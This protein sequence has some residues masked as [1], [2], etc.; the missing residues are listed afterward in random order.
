MASRIYHNPVVHVPQQGRERR[1]SW[2]EL[3]YDLA[4]VAVLIQLGSSLAAHSG[5]RGI[6]GFVVLFVPVWIAWTGFTFYSNRF[7]V[8]DVVHRVSVFGQIFATSAMAL[9]VPEVFEGQTSHFALSYAVLR[10]LQLIMYLRTWWQEPS[11]QVFTRHFAFVYAVDA[12]LW[13]LSTMLLSPWN[14]LAWLLGGLAS[15][16]VPFSSQAHQL[17][18]KYSPDAAHMAERYGLL[19][20]IVLG[21]TFLKSLTSLPGHPVG[22]QIGVVSAMIVIAFGIWWIY[23]DDVAGSRL[24]TSRLTTFAWIYSHLPLTMAITMIGVSAKKFITAASMST[25]VPSARWILCLSVATVLACMA[26]LD[27]V[28]ERRNVALNDR[29]RIQIRLA[30]AGIVILLGAA[31]ALLPPLVLLSLVAI[32]VLVQ[33]IAD[34]AIAPHD[35]SLHGQVID[36]TVGTGSRAVI[37]PTRNRS[38]TPTAEALRLG[39]PSELRSDFYFYLL[40]GSW[41]RLIASLLGLYVALNFVFA[42]LYVIGPNSILNARSNSLADAFFFSVQ[43]MS[44][45][46][47]GTM[48][49]GTTYG[50]IIMTIEMMASLMLV[51]VATGLMFAKAARPKPSVLFSEPIVISRMNAMDTLMLRVANGR[52]NEIVSAQLVLSALIDEVSPEGHRIRRLQDLKLVRSTSPVFN[53]SWLVMHRI[54]ESSPLWGIDWSNPSSRIYSIIATLTGHDSAYSQ[55]VYARGVWQPEDIYAGYRFIDVVST[56]DDGRLILDF[57]KFHAIEPDPLPQAHAP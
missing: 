44:T 48:S 9:T 19:T 34:L 33:V 15:L 10:V 21:E 45:V 56:A 31:S 14:Y 52:G 40:E 54:D 26:V 17:A 23:F 29:M 47:Y 25:L 13:L 55:T 11:T 18:A 53:L 8:D 42:C 32:V 36:P 1:S 57:T 28:T 37:V 4:Y 5:P 30:G 38:R 43:T 51:A 50:H 20:I 24:K 41:F 7:V 16:S 3:F 22:A 39:V 49:P 35:E 46:G 12:G 2:L 27:S 6:A